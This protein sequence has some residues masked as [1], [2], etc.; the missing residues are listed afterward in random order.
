MDTVLN[1]TL[2]KGIGTIQ[3][4]LSLS[5][6]V[7]EPFIFNGDYRYPILPHIALERLA[8]GFY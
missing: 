6:L 4:P 1:I 3:V 5:P 2:K 8:N 7:S